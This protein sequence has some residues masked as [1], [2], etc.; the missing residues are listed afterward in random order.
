[1]S[2]FL[3]A[4]AGYEPSVRLFD[5]QNA[6][7]QRTVQFQDSTVSALAFSNGAQ[8]VHIDADPLYLAV[9]GSPRVAVYDATAPPPPPGLL[10][11]AEAPPPTVA[12]PLFVFEG[13]SAPV[14]TVGFD[15]RS[16][17]PRFGYSASE[18]GWLKVWD[19]KLPARRGD[20]PAAM[21]AVPTAETLAEFRRPEDKPKLNAA[22]LYN[23]PGADRHGERDH[24]EGGET[25]SD[26][27]GGDVD[28]FITAD[29]KGR[30]SMWDYNAR[31]LVATVRPHAVY[32]EEVSTAEENR[33][34]G[35]D[36]G[37]NGSGANERE[38]ETGREDSED[39]GERPGGDPFDHRAVGDTV[40][41][42]ASTDAASAGSASGPDASASR[43]RASAPPKARGWPTRRPRTNTFSSLHASQSPYFKPRYGKQEARSIDRHG[44][45]LQTLELFSAADGSGTM[46]VTADT[47]GNIFLYHVTA[48]LVNERTPAYATWNA[49]KEP[50]PSA[51]A[52]PPLASSPPKVYVTRTRVS[53]DGK[54]LACTLSTGTLRLYDLE[55]DLPNF[56]S[57]VN[58]EMSSFRDCHRHSGCAWDAA[59]VGD[60]NNYVFTCGS[61]SQ[62]LLWFL[63]DDHPSDYPGHNRA[64]VCLAVKEQFSSNSVACE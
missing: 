18:D 51:A 43:P 19:P 11:H 40:E 34:G 49:L 61:D 64:V 22:V 3:L 7:L 47:L 58:K 6:K 8:P 14:T 23:G 12:A 16:P 27:G 55:K 50:L 52:T 25:G 60:A 33:E 35:E 13:H 57:G 17:R 41:A 24:G 1:M 54:V 56:I 31:C 20:P 39:G 9:A 10:P 30:L 59:F 26:G 28:V 63:D 38:E 21:P 36:G 42:G 62:V 44:V 32:D 45:H 5:A 2:Y 53:Q 4:T 37:T 15:A 46:L 29:A 48:M